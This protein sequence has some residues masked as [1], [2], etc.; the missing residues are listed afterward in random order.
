M[1]SFS[2]A[3]LI[4]THLDQN[5][6]E[7]FNEQLDQTFGNSSILD[8]FS[9]LTPSSPKSK[10]YDESINLNSPKLLNFINND[11]SDEREHLKGKLSN[12]ARE[13]QSV[14]DE[15]MLSW[16]ILESNHEF[17]PQNIND[18]TISKR[19]LNHQLTNDDNDNNVITKSTMKQP[20]SPYFISK[21]LVNI[22]LKNQHDKSA[23]D[24]IT[25]H[26]T[27]SDNSIEHLNIINTQKDINNTDLTMNEK[28]MLNNVNFKSISNH[29]DNSNNY[30]TELIKKLE[31][32]K[33][34][35]SICRS[36]GMFSYTNCPTY[37]VPMT[38]M[39]ND[40]KKS[41]NSMVTINRNTNDNPVYYGINSDF[42]TITTTGS[43][44]T[45]MTTAGTSENEQL[46]PRIIS[47]QPK[48]ITT[49]ITALPTIMNS[50]SSSIT[51]RK[52]TRAAFSH[53]QVYELEKRFNYQRY[54][55]ATERAEL[56]RSLR[57]S[58]TQVKIWFQNRRYKTK[59]RLMN[60]MLNPSNHSSD[61]SVQ[62]DTH[63]D[64]FNVQ[65]SMSAENSM[66]EDTSSGQFH[67]NYDQQERRQ[68]LHREQ[69]QIIDKIKNIFHLT[70]IPHF[71]SKMP[72]SE[73][74]DNFDAIMSSLYQNHQYHEHQNNN[75]HNYRNRFNDQSIHQMN[76]NVKQFGSSQYFGNH[77]KPNDGVKISNLKRFTPSI[78]DDEETKRPLLTDLPHNHS[79][80]NIPLISN[81][82]NWKENSKLS[83]HHHHY[84]LHSS[85]DE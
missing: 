21:S 31:A 34:F 85:V 18:F 55:S 41:T 15:H 58:E 65:H 8:T 76:E 54:L 66:L 7:S 44:M 83:H 39:I 52:R 64:E 74:L 78:S 48:S 40:E 35:Y 26:C 19:S 75:H 11:I 4:D 62:N 84:N 22:I 14:G 43:E 5:N 59:K 60:S 67:L 73:L 71:I 69:V 10:L 81:L 32:Y 63:L 13:F 3:N 36:K 28:T 46:T 33:L 57:L 47:L 50:T 53:A 24:K 1:D 29:S 79:Y 61:D 72:R 70:E 30:L 37:S 12:S 9:S 42:K 6:H 56:A 45:I 20:L 17:I 80:G 49:T 38:S 23:E 77:F 27:F 68:Q 2:I 51:R 82:S 16:N 25:D